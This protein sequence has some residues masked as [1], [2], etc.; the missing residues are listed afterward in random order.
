VRR[1]RSS[2]CSRL[3]RTAALAALLASSACATAGTGAPSPLLTE[4][5][6]SA[7]VRLIYTRPPLTSRNGRPD[8]FEVIE[9][10]RS[11]DV[12]TKYEGIWNDDTQTLTDQIA[13]PVGSVNLVF[14]ND[15]SLTPG[16]VTPI[17][18]SREGRLREV[19][20]PRVVNALHA[21]YELTVTKG[22]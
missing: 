13:L 16:S 5:S 3:V 12:I 9:D 2:R 21:C 6:G 8:G 18:A 4:Q 1:S 7:F 17:T 22:H 11:S 14:I 19:A 15:E 10:Y 20:C